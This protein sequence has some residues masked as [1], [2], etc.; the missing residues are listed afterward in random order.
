MIL[1]QS[2]KDA[3][4]IAEGDEHFHTLKTYFDNAADRIM[5]KKGNMNPVKK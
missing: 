3:K 2:S 5:A 4:V 1:N